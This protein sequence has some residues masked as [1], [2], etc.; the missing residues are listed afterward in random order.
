MKALSI[1]QPWAWA[2]VQGLKPVENRT[3]ATKY[4]GPLLIHAAKTFDYDGFYWINNNIGRSTSLDQFQMGGII[5]QVN[6]VDSVQEFD[7]KWFFG[8]YGF[9]LEDPKPLPFTPMRGRLG[10]FDVDWVYI[11]K[12]EEK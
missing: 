6:L 9:V 5:G 8:P 7:S 12:V 3:W 4:R 11:S 2:I 1:R 10:L